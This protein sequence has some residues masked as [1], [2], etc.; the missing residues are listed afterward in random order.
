M[1]E[2]LEKLKASR[3]K[4]LFL[5]GLAVLVVLVRS[6]QLQ[7]LQY[8]KFSRLA[9]RNRTVKFPR[10][11][12][13]GMILDRKGRVLAEA[14]A[15][16]SLYIVRGFSRDL[17][18]TLK[19]IAPILE[20]TVEVLKGRL[21]EQK[22][23]PKLQPVALADNLSISQ[24]SRLE[25][26]REVFPEILVEAEPSRFYPYGKLAAHVV[27]YV[28]EVSL[29][30]VKRMGLK[31]GE[32]V[33][34]KGVEKEY[35][36]QLRGE[37]GY[38]EVLRD[39]LGNPIKVLKEV[40]PRA[41]R[42]LKLS[43]DLDLQ[44]IAR[45]EMG[46]ERGAVVIV[47][48]TTGEILA[49]VS[50]PS[51]DPNLMSSRFSGREKVKI[52]TSPDKPLFTRAIQGTYPIGSIFKLAVA[53]AALSE[54]VVKPGERL[55]CPGFF[56]FGGRL[57]RCWTSAGHGWEN[58][59]MAIKDSC[60]VY[61]YKVGKRLGIER[62]VKVVSKFPFG[63][64]T[65][66]DLPGERAGILPSPE[67]KRKRFGVDWYPGETLSLSIGQG[68]FVAT[69]LQVVLFLSAIANRGWYPIPHLKG[70]IPPVKIPTGLSPSVFRWVIRGMRLAVEE[71]TARGAAV[72]GISV[73][74]KTGTAQV[75]RLEKSKKIKPHSLFAAFAPCSN[76]R[77]AI[78]VLVEHGGAGG[79]TAAP[80]AGRILRRI[81]HE[82][83][84]RNR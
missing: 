16:F 32:I 83:A 57:F 72:P 30:E 84:A 61:F 73:C 52:M 71:G 17:E 60:N 79:K 14:R 12:P 66:V 28:G 10:R 76:P 33:G 31:P 80:M 64:R 29:G 5:V 41:G 67:W 48:P 68:Y 18:K 43:L 13:R 21:E 74:G 27:G 4:F 22:Y 47:S 54:G 34:K 46:G 65:G 19:I 24:V 81:F 78:L 11:A 49:M 53:I 69:P 8:R 59:P 36:A 15:T 37:E 1:K 50:S 25:A 35:D 58:L 42:D 38:V 20:T 56:P 62:M 6:F 26:L 7:V 40:L 51:F 39:S 82:K 77:V 44:K 45:E 55:F 9:E 70:D 23:L 2:S 75:V 63:R 3:V